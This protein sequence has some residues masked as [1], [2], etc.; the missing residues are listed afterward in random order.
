MSSK[1]QKLHPDHVYHI[2]NRTKGNDLMFTQERNYQFFLK[3]YIE[4]LHPFLDTYKYYLLDNHFHFLIKIKSEAEIKDYLQTSDFRH[5]TPSAVDK[6]C[7]EI[8]QLQ[9]QRFFG[10]YAKAFNKQE[11]RPGSLPERPFKRKLIAKES[12]FGYAVY[13]IHSNSEKH[14]LSTN[15]RTWQW[16]SYQ[17][18]LSEKETKLKR[19]FILDWRGR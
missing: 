2:F 7:I 11:N 16:S 6:N 3:K 1:G 8:I 18:Y 13:Y 15:F 10:S 14:G 17:S 12:Y 4:Y 19:D 9:F 5:K